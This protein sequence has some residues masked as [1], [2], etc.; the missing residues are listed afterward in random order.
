[1]TIPRA[2]AP[3]APSALPYA[4]LLL[5][6]ADRRLDRQAR[7]DL[8]IKAAAASEVV[9]VG[10]ANAPCWTV[11]CGIR[12]QNVTTLRCAG[13]CALDRCASDARA[14]IRAACPVWRRWAEQAMGD[15]VSAPLLSPST[16]Q[17]RSEP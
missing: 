13:A 1:M 5:R 11:F 2:Q 12:Q 10:P 7:I 8:A 3:A 17:E 9:D 4:D 6:M 14:Q 15:K 16:R